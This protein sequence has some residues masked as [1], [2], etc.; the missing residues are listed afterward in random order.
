MSFFPPLHFQAL[1]ALEELCH[2]F[3][4]ATVPRILWKGGSALESSVQPFHRQQPHWSVNFLWN[5]VGSRQLSSKYEPIH[6]SKKTP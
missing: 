4:R 3:N 5:F 6:F 2:G 1:G